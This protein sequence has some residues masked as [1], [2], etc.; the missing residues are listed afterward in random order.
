MEGNIHQVRNSKEMQYVLGN[1][2]VGMALCSASQHLARVYGCM[3]TSCTK[4]SAREPLLMLFHLHTFYFYI[5]TDP[6]QFVGEPALVTSHIWPDVIVHFKH[7][8]RLT[9][10]SL[11]ISLEAIFSSVLCLLPLDLFTPRI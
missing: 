4:Q 8:R 6:F 2:A 7:L 5:K 9:Q 3:R 1:K 10:S 11:L